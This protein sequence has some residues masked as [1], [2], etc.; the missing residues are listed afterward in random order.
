MISRVRSS[1][2]VWLK[3]LVDT[4]VK[5]GLALAALACLALGISALVGGAEGL[6]IATIAGPVLAIAIVNFIFESFSRN[7][8]AEDIREML[9]REHRLTET[10]LRDMLDARAAAP[11][12]VVGTSASVTVLPWHPTQWAERDFRPLCELACARKLALRVFVPA[13]E[14]TM[15]MAFA[16]RLGT[17]P[18]KLASDLA[19]LPDELCSAWDG[20]GVR[21]DSTLEV[22]TYPG[23]P[24]FGLLGSEAVAAVDLGPAIRRGAFDASSQLSIFEPGSPTARA[25]HEQLAA[26]EQ[27]GARAGV[28]PLRRPEPRGGQ[29]HPL[30]DPEEEGDRG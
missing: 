8:L 13:A 27:D 20:V 4:S 29:P 17:A 15:I 22:W 16:D 9:G 14:E 12:M 28:R 25:I 3:R 24:A 10:G 30:A 5:A 19:S 23:L 18:S 26:A 21:T 1:R 6:V 11:A 7:A 2:T